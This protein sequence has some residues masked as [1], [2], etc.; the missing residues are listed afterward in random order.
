MQLLDLSRQSDAALSRTLRRLGVSLTVGEGREVCRL[1]GRDPTLTELHIFNT[2]WSEHCSYKSSRAHLSKLPTAAPWVIQG[3]QEDAGIVELCEHDGARWGIV[4]GHES[5]NHPSQIVPYEGAATG[6]GGIIRDVLCMGARVIAV[7]DALRFGNPD[8]RHGATVRYIADGVVSGVAGYGNAVGVPNLAGDVYWDAGYDGN[9]LVNV[10]C[11]GLVRAD[12][13]IHS[14]APEGAV[15]W[16]VVLIGKATDFSGFGGAAFSS[17]VLSVEDADAQKGAVQVPDPFLKSVIIRATEEVFAAVRRQGLTVGFK[18]LGAGGISCASSE[19][20]DAAGVGIEVDLDRVHLAVPD[21]PPHVVACAE[22]QE[23]LLWIV[24][25]AFTP[26]LLGFYNETFD[27]PGAAEGAQARVIGRTRPDDRYVLTAGGETVCDA[28]V[29][30][31]CR[32]IRYDRVGREPAVNASAAPPEPLPQYDAIA[33]QVL[34]APGVASKWAIYSRYDQEVQGNTVLRPGEGDAGVLAPLPGCPVGVAL[35]TDCTPAYCRLDPYRGAMMAV[36]EAARNVSAV[37]ATPRALTDCLNMGDPGDP[38]AFWAFTEAV[39]G[40]ADAAKALGPEGVA[41]PPLPFISGN[42]SFYNQTGGRQAIPPSPIVA[43]VGVLPDYTKAV[44]MQV[45]TAGATLLLVGRRPA[46]FG[47]S[48]YEA[49]RQ[50]PAGEL[51]PLDLDAERCANAAVVDLIEQRLVLA[52]H[53]ISDGGLL[54]CVSEMLLGARGEGRLGAALHLAGVADRADAALFSEAG[55]YLLAVTP[56]LLPGIG[57]VLARYGVEAREIGYTGG[58]RL[59]A[60]FDEHTVLDA[61]V[62]ALATTWLNAVPEAMA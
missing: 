46:C 2:Q 7:A 59:I 56:A 52:A 55:G 35:T 53:D 33:L 17:G 5:H 19:M 39:R 8:G 61:P 58:D 12:Q 43:C 40:L 36:A 47:G 31:V 23:R 18:D 4:F 21:V 6:I 10:V 15:G 26:E 13:I 38:G 27:L 28:P 48:V 50:A 29:A 20:G 3:P 54:A 30:V 42:V 51:P 62:E 57:R 16:D 22:T 9:C 32:G 24:P 34:G 49:V 60:T 37:G 44:G 1:I 45:T 11:L 25:P 14:R 41:G